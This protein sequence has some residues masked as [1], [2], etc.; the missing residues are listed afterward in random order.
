MSYRVGIRVRL[1]PLLA[2]TC[3]LLGSGVSQAAARS[4]QGCD[5]DPNDGRFFTDA[6]GTSIT[7]SFTPGRAAISGFEIAV[8]NIQRTAWRGPLGAE[9][10]LQSPTVNGVSVTLARLAA[11]S[12]RP[13]VIPS[14]RRTWLR[15]NLV[16]PISRPSVGLPAIRI[17]VPAADKATG[18]PPWA[19][20]RCTGS[21][22]RGEASVPPFNPAGAAGAS[23][24]VELPNDAQFRTY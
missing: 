13:V 6:V 2:A 4:D 22:M 16:T 7:Q 5:Q 21:Y 17:A 9:L 20:L 24:Q 23:T 8:A 18:I 11:V 19:W 15:F 10:V 1:L 12:P 14:L 3:L